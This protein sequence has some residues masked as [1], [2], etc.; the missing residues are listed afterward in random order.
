MKK[1]PTITGLAEYPHMPDYTE[2]PDLTGLTLRQAL[3]VLRKIPFGDLG[4]MHETRLSDGSYIAVGLQQDEAGG[5]ILGS[6][7]VVRY[8]RR[9]EPIRTYNL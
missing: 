3:A 2:R 8:D 9:H 6:Q 1:Q 4:G 5:W 7:R